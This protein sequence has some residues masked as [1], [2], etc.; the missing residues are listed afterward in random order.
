MFGARL[1]K[2]VRVYPTV[3]IELPWNLVLDDDAT[4]GDCAILY[5][6]GKI[7]CGKRVTVSQYAHLCA[8]THDFEDPAFPLMK[9]PISIGNDVWVCA[10]AFIGPNVC[11]GDGCVVGARAVVVKSVDSGVVVAGNP[12]RVIRKRKS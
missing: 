2:R 1:G 4:V 6:L 9:L 12:A 10:D 7:E 5:A 3:K 11:L 8:G